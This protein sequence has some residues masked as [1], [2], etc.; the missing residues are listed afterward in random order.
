MKTTLLSH[1]A[2]EGPSILTVGVTDLMTSLAV[3]FILLFTAYVTKTSETESQAQDIKE[4]IR[5]VLQ[6]PFSAVPAVPRCRPE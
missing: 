4:D 5:S 6:R 2:D 3:I 1:E